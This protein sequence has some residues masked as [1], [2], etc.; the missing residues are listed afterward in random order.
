MTHT[1]EKIVNELR[2]KEEF[3]G[4]SVKEIEKE[5]Y[6]VL[7]IDF[8][9][10]AEEEISK[11]ILPTPLFR[12]KYDENQFQISITPLEG[13]ALPVE[14]N[15]ID[16]DALDITLAF[17]L[18]NIPLLWVGETGT[19]KTITTKTFGK[20]VLPKGSYVYKRLAGSIGS[21][22]LLG[23]FTKI[24]MSTGYPRP[25]LDETKTKNI[26]MLFIDEANR[27][28]DDEKMQLIDG[29]VSIGGKSSLLGPII[30]ELNQNGEVIYNDNNRKKIFVVGAINP[31]EGMSKNGGYLTTR[32]LDDAERRRWTI[33][34]FGDI[35]SAGESIDLTTENPHR[36]E[37]FLNNFIRY[38]SEDLNIDRE[39]LN[40][41]KDDWLSIYAY[42]TDSKKNEHPVLYTAFEFSDIV[43]LV[44]NNN[45]EKTLDEEIETIDMINR[46]LSPKYNIRIVYSHRI[47]EDSNTVKRIKE[48][49]NNLQKESPADIAKAGSLAQG[50][51][52]IRDI[53]FAFKTSNPI[54]Y[55][56]NLEKADG[57]YVYNA[58]NIADI[59]Y[60][61][62]MVSLS[63]SRE[64]EDSFKVIPLV[65]ELLNEYNEFEY[66]F[67][68]DLFG[69]KDYMNINDTKRG[70]KLPAIVKSIR[71]SVTK[72]NEEG[73][74]DYVTYMIKMLAYE[75]NV[76]N[77]RPNTDLAK[78][79]GGRFVSDLAVFA[80]FLDDY[81]DEINKEIASHQNPTE[82]DVI[83]IIYSVYTNM[84]IKHARAM[85]E[86][87]LHRIPRILGMPV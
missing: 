24:D 12:L 74:K 84:K 43:A 31:D 44:L 72:A 16:F 45:L 76:I 77:K 8:I 3:K 15:S 87:Y 20:T 18:R 35:V 36:F 19:G 38:L 53:K 29:E 55:L 14:E 11:E 1:L 54:E 79:M 56:K 28:R 70:V 75:C 85:P 49:L 60:A 25:V 59:A 13:Y 61:W 67:Q 21:S 51:K 68:N 81:K 83:D 42:I 82:D 6:P 73:N 4:K 2:T 71:Y 33:I 62:A 7:L 52:T 23:N 46:K 80:E 78:L 40:S 64:I 69:S 63:K 58:V 50:I 57:T 86:I 26:A 5:L 9:K 39:K 17:L 32:A 34:E 47:D 66:A 10:S 48:I 22:S 37:N 30:P 41:L 65:N 27:G